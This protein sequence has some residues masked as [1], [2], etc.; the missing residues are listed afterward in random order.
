MWT[1]SSCINNGKDSALSTIGMFYLSDEVSNVAFKFKHSMHKLCLQE[2]V[3][4]TDS[5]YAI[6]YLTV[7]KDS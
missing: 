3:I 1:D 6:K 7:Y 2:Y 4:H 5:E